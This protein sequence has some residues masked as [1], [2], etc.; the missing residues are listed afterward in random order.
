MKPE[1]LFMK[2]ALGFCSLLAGLLVAIAV[3]AIIQT[4][5]ILAWLVIVVGF[6]F[7]LGHVICESI[8]H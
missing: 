4:P 3:F 8:Y 5:M 2:F 6:S 7:A 1:D